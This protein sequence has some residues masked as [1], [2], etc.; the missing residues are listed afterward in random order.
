[1]T[2]F[3]ALEVLKSQA[4]AGHTRQISKS[5]A[6][7]DVMSQSPRL[8][9][10]PTSEIDGVSDDREVEAI[11]RTDVAV[12]KLTYVESESCGHLDRLS[13]VRQ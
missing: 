1:M 11:A 9:F 12:M 2:V 8:R 5:A 3:Y 13:A 4:L 6:A 7:E 10:N